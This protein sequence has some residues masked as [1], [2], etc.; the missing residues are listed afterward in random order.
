MGIEQ[1]F[2]PVIYGYPK[3]PL[4]YAAATERPMHRFTGPLA[5]DRDTS[6]NDICH[7]RVR[8]VPS[9]DLVTTVF[10]EE[11]VRISKEFHKL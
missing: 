6:D 8:P 10:R 5:A 11:I 4:R 2:M 9:H 7:T 3:N 1:R